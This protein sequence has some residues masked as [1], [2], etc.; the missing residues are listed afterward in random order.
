MTDNLLLENGDSLLLENGNFI[1][2][3]WVGVVSGFVLDESAQ[4]IQRTV[5]L[6]N[7]STGNLIGEVV[8]GTDG[9][10]TFADVVN[11][12]HYVVALDD[13]TDADDFNALIFDFIIPVAS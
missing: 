5:R 6:Y 10:F 8:S 1:K 12:N 11:E 13:E 9:S 3:D 7:R 4:G 2:I